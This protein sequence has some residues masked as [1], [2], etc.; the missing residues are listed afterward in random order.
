MN[1]SLKQYTFLQPEGKGNTQ[2][3]LLPISLDQFLNK[4]ILK[5]PKHWLF[6]TYSLFFLKMWK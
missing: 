5:E 4:G 2:F 6:K 1:E 3:N